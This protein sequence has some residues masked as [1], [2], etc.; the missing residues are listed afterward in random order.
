MPVE[1]PIKEARDKR[2]DELLKAEEELYKKQ[3]R[4]IEVEE[5]FC[6]DVLKARTASTSLAKA[7]AAVSK[8]LL[9]NDINS[10][11]TG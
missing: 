2:L 4:A 6:R 5:A 8:P 9:I 3:M 1:D 11:L 7:N 10:F